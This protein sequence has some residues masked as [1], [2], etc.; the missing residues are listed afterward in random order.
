MIPIIKII[1]YI[2]KIYSYIILARILLSWFPID[3][4]NPI[5]RLIYKITEPILEPFRVI[6]SLD[7]MGLDLSPIIVLFLLNILRTSLIR[8]IINIYY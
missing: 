3:H 7:G 6:I 2:F 8:L 5:V 1:N 4:N